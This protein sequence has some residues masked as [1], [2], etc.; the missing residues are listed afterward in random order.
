MDTKNYAQWS[1]EELQKEEKKIKNQEI[2]SAVIVGFLVGVMIYGLVMNGF[3]WVYTLIPLLL[4][5][6]IAKNSQNLKEK[7][8]Q[9]Q[10]AMGTESTE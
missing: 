5:G 7:R 10:T 2:T 4:I 6:G 8:K 9:I 1:R 3:G